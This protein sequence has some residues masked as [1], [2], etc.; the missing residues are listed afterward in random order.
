MKITNNHVYV[1][2]EIGINHEGSVTKCSEMINE[3]ASIGVDAI[4]LQTINADA[5]YVINS[6]SYKVFKGSELT[7]EETSDMFNLARSKGLDV[8]T[9]SG[10]IETIKWVDTLKPSCW[11]VSS[12][13]LT[14]IPVIRYLA[15]LGRPLLISTG[16]A[17][18]DEI[19]LAIKTARAVGNN[20]ISLL[21]CT[22]SV[23][24]THLTLPT[25]CSV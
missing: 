14:H 21:Q 5:N 4:K 6:E 25:I 8:F 19:G 11:K 18:H 13:L 23:S 9:T 10:D 1:I 16:M 7:Q 12:G 15:S 20:D 2:A 24:Y 17:N 3:A 22:S